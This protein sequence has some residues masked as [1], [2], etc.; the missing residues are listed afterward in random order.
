MEKLTGAEVLVK[1]LVAAGVECAFMKEHPET[2]PIYEAAAKENSI[3]IISPVSETCCVPMADGYT[4]YSGKPAAAITAGGGHLLNQAP[5]VTSAWADKSPVISI[6]VCGD[7]SESVSPIFDRENWNQAMTFASVSRWSAT[8]SQWRLIP[9]MVRRAIQEAMS[10][11]GG[12]AHIEIPRGL[13]KHKEEI[14]DDAIKRICRAGSLF[15]QKQSPP[16]GDPAKVRAAFDLLRNAKKP[17]IIA[18]GGVIKA[19]AVSEINELAEKLGIPITS[20][21]GGMG[22]ALP[23]NPAYLGAASYLSGEAFHSAIKQADVVLA[24]GCCFSG[25]DGFGLPPLWSPKIKFIQVNVDAEDIAINP[26]AE[27]AIVG[28]AKRIMSQMLELAAKSP[29]RTGVSDWL[30][31]LKR[32]NQQH[33][34][35]IADEANRPWKL[36]HP[37]IIPPIL[38]DIAGKSDPIVVLDGGNTALWAGMLI[39][40]PGPRRGFFPV[41][42]GTLGLGIPVS[43]GVKAAAGDKPVMIV[44]GDGA[45][46]YNI[47]ELETMR[48]YNMPI[49]SVV[50]ND[51][52]WNM[53]RA[54]QAMAGEVFGTDLPSQDYAAVA[55]SFGLE[56][57]RVTRKEDIGPVFREMFNSGKPGVMDIVTDP[58]SIPDSLISFARVEFDGASM[59][60]SKLLGALRKKSLK[61]L[62]IRLLNLVKF[63]AKT[64]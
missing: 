26:P 41:G 12:P 33:L 56:G 24:V 44:T 28:D 17:L 19:D 45:F 40:V 29:A 11:R 38:N 15:A 48:K 63:I 35:R 46:L 54:G 49:V 8:I 9:E 61:D 52:A 55:R 25:L 58:D 20:T 5:G 21:M 7:Q 4:R 39:P 23:E 60:P 32:R 16:R 37:G 13:L 43:I 31:T 27:I 62:D 42:M 10:G 1:A 64:R 53:I 57:K 2:E 51:S 59:P 18:G 36:I 22:A 14:S 6:G 3:R 30:G 34:D 47:Q 50:L